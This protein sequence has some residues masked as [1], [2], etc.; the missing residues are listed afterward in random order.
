MGLQRSRTRNVA[1][2]QILDSVDKDIPMF[3]TA[4]STLAVSLQPL[5]SQVYAQ[6]YG[7]RISKMLL[8]LTG[9]PTSL[10]PEGA[11]VCVDVAIDE[12]P[13][14]RVV[15]S[16]TWSRHTVVHLDWFPEGQRGEY[17]T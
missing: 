4:Y 9:K 15:S 14:Y 13:D 17:G 8:L 2:H 3:N 7:T 12:P 1:I 6:I 5:D 16:K 10:L 11:G